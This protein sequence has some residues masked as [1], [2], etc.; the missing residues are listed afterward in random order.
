MNPFFTIIIP[1]FNVAPHLRECL[2]SVLKQSF[3]DWEAI[4]VDDG[5][6]AS[7]EILNKYFLPRTWELNAAPVKVNNYTESGYRVIA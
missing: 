4:C 7:A 6:D 2:D 1:V 5:S 3:S